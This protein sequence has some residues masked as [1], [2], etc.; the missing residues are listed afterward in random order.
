[1]QNA[2]IGLND[3]F[4]ESGWQWLDGSVA[5]Y[6][7][8]KSPQPDNWLGMEDCVDIDAS[9]YWNDVSCNL[10]KSYVCERF[11][12]KILLIFLFFL[13]CFNTLEFL[14]YALILSMHFLFFLLFGICFF[15]LDD[16][17][18]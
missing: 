10:K 9:G 1:M 11:N 14:L 4:H 12:S 2:Y 15:A 3:I 17:Y 5:N 6:F 7:N 8:F 16:N 13:F 18:V